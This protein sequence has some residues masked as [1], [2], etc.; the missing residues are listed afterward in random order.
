[1]QHTMSYSVGGRVFDLPSDKVQGFLETAKA[2]G[3][4]PEEAYSYRVSGKDGGSREFTIPRSKYDGFKQTAEANGDTVEPLRTMTMADG[5]RRS[6]TMKEMADYLR[7]DEYRNSQDAKDAR[8]EIEKRLP[9]PTEIGENR[10]FGDEL[11]ASGGGAIGRM[12]GSVVSGLFHAGG[13]LL[14]NAAVASPLGMPG[15]N[16][17]GV[18]SKRALE[19]VKDNSADKA[20]NWVSEWTNILFPEV[21]ANGVVQKATA[22]TAELGAGLA[23][24]GIMA[25][26]PYSLAALV[27]ENAGNSSYETYD[28][29]I[30]GGMSPEEANGLAMARGFVD[31]GI[32]AAFAAAP[33]K[34]LANA[35]GLKTQNVALPA[36]KDA[37]K[38]GAKSAKNQLS[39]GIAKAMAVE[40]AKSAAEMGGLTYAQ[41]FFDNAVMQEAANPDAPID[42]EKAAKDAGWEALEQAGMGAALGLLPTP[43]RIAKARKALNASIA[44][45]V[46]APNGAETFMGVN[47]QGAA[48]L[49]DAYRKNGSVSRKDAAR[50]GLPEMNEADRN[51]VAKRIVDVQERWDTSKETAAAEHKVVEARMAENE[52]K[53]AMG[54]RIEREGEIQRENAAQSEYEAKMTAYEEA[55]AKRAAEKKRGVAKDKLTPL[56]EKPTPPELRVEK[57]KKPVAEADLSEKTE[58]PISEM[59]IEELRKA[60]SEAREKRIEANHA[61]SKLRDRS[62]AGDEPTKAEIEEADA[63]AGKWFR[64]EEETLQRL[65]ELQNPKQTKV[66]DGRGRMVEKPVIE[67]DLTDASKKTAQVGKEAAEKPFEAATKAGN[68]GENLSPRE[69]DDYETRYAKEKA[70]FDAKKPERERKLADVNARIE[71]NDREIEDLRKSFKGTDEELLKSDRRNELT[72]KLGE[73][74]KEKSSIEGELKESET[75]HDRNVRENKADISYV[76]SHISY[77][78]QL[79]K[80]ALKKGESA[81]VHDKYIA[82]YES[83]LKTLKGDTDAR[84]TIKAIPIEPKPAKVPD[85]RGRMV[86]KPSWRT[87]KVDEVDADGKPYTE[88]EKMVLRQMKALDFIDYNQGR[89]TS[90]KEYEKVVKAF[91]EIESAQPF[92]RGINGDVV[93]GSARRVANVLATSK[94]ATPEEKA[95]F[96]EY[97][98]GKPQSPQP[99]ENTPSRAPQ[100][101]KPMSQAEAAK[102][103]EAK[104]GANGAA[105]KPKTYEEIAKRLDELTEVAKPKNGQKGDVVAGNRA[106]G[107]KAVAFALGYDYSPKK[108]ILKSQLE[109]IAKELR[110]NEQPFDNRNSEM[111]KLYD[112]RREGVLEAIKDAGLE[113]YTDENG[114]TQVRKAK[115]VKTPSTRVPDGKGR[116]VK[117]TN[118]NGV[119]EKIA[120]AE[121]PIGLHPKFKKQNA[122][123]MAKIG[124]FSKDGKMPVAIEGFD[125]GASKPNYVEFK[126]DDG[127]SQK[128]YG[129]INSIMKWADGVGLKPSVRPAPVAQADGKSKTKS[130]AAPAPKSTAPVVEK[131][132]G[133]LGTSAEKLKAEERDAKKRFKSE[134]ESLL[135]ALETARVNADNPQ[136]SFSSDEKAK[137][138]WDDAFTKYR[139]LKDVELGKAEAK[140]EN[141][142]RAIIRDKWRS[143]STANVPDST[144]LARS[145]K[146]KTAQKAIADIKA[147]IKQFENDIESFKGE[148][149]RVKVGNTEYTIKNNPFALRQFREN[150]QKRFGKEASKRYYEIDTTPVRDK[151]SD[152]DFIAWTKKQGRTPTDGARR[153]YDAQRVDA[154]LKVAKNWL[155]GVT[156]R[157]TENAAEVPNGARMLYSKD[158]NVVGWYDRAKNEVV[159]L[160]GA[161][162]AT[163]AHELGWHATYDY[164]QA[165]AAQGR[166][167]LLDKLN[168]YAANAPQAVKNEILRK[169]GMATDASTL[170]DEIGAARYTMDNVNKIKDAATRRQ[171]AKW[172]QRT[173]NA[174]ADTYKAMLSKLGW[175]KARLDNLSALTPEETVNLLADEM[176]KGRNLGKA[177]STQIDMSKGESIAQLHDRKLKDRL[178]PI[179]EIEKDA[180]KSVSNS[181]H[182]LFRLLP[183]KV[184]G[185]IDKAQNFAEKVKADC[186]KAGIKIE[187]LN[188]FLYASAAS[189]RNAKVL[190]R[191]GRLDGSAMSHADIQRI[192]SAYRN[193]PK[194]A[195]LRRIADDV[196]AFQRKGFDFRRKAGLI[197]DET[198]NTL[199]ADEPNHVP[200][201]NRFDPNGE[202][203]GF[204]LTEQFG[205]PEW[206]T[207]EGR[208]NVGDGPLEWIVQEYVDAFSRGHENV[209]RRAL[210][211]TVLAH[212]EVGE[213]KKL[214]PNDALG[215]V[216][217]KG[218]Q[219]DPNVFVVKTDGD[220]YQVKLNGTRGELIARAVSG[221]GLLRAP[222]SLQKAMRWWSSTATSWSPTFAGRNFLADTVD[223]FAVNVGENGLIKGTGKFVK[224]VHTALKLTNAIRKYASTGE[225][226]NPL[227]REAV[228]AG[229]LMGGGVRSQ[230]FADSGEAALKTLKTDWRSGKNRFKAVRNAMFGWVDTLNQTAELMNRMADYKLQREAGKSKNEAALHAR[231]ITVDFNEKGELTPVTNMLYMFS[232]STLGATMRLNKAI[233]ASKEGKSLAAGVF[234]WGLVEGMA[235]ALTNGDDEDGKNMNE[236]TR[237]N[238]LYFRNGKD[239]YRIPLHASPIS[240]IKYAGNCTARK[241]FGTLNGDKAAEQ[242]AKDMIGIMT[243]YLGIGALGDNEAAAIAP[244][245]VQPFLQAYMNRDFADRPIERTSF[246]EEK[247]K[248]GNGRPST[249]QFYKDLAKWLNEF[250]G[251]NAG[252]KGELNLLGEKIG[253]DFSPEMLKHFAEATGKNALRD[254]ENTVEFAKMVLGKTDWDRRNIP[255]GRDYFRTTGGNDNRFFEAVRAYKT[256][257][258]ELKNKESWADGEKAAYRKSHP[259]LRKGNDGKTTVN[260]LINMTNRDN[261]RSGIG[262]MGITQLRKLTEGK[263]RRKDGSYFEPK[264]PIDDAKKEKANEWLQKRQARVIEIMGK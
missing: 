177:R 17:S 144:L 89:I 189:E 254:I 4:A 182:T 229:V 206:K 164:A 95:R 52:Q 104:N 132:K 94:F 147:K 234:A 20:G 29:A 75:P 96:K 43:V 64:I 115:A 245:I 111:A 69:K 123:E 135:A 184:Q 211:E 235:E 60:H 193:S 18:D 72:K 232:N 170:L 46:R 33:V 263:I 253:T 219:G 44:D 48:E 154:V 3:D 30:R 247:P 98:E 51:S 256:D 179:E 146:Y 103:V 207:A 221:R 212:P 208:T 151:L 39:A 140:L 22:K 67:A 76:K 169:Y 161:D 126:Y 68:G 23:K 175:N 136:K 71:E 262:S 218:Q 252:R 120:N 233:F 205:K 1:M 152:P 264:T 85:G 8:A 113:A 220:T 171:T 194:Y 57:Q 59:S 187:E 119:Y 141:V 109:Q 63:E 58:K 88:A 227:I 198:W 74:L 24:F 216:K 186:K 73:L 11:N 204:S 66:P 47:P 128:V 258:E 133:G 217:R 228:D 78:K 196:L 83:L 153:I 261:P 92:E 84:E 238:S 62:I 255:V 36:V 230:A 148:D 80:N 214:G 110:A 168:D 15:M 199:L 37:I 50:A 185:A 49:A 213:V 162:A 165:E 55:R 167:A 101:A 209:A 25:S 248:S 190:A 91:D 237:A 107:Y 82:K 87:S 117:K 129:D 53:A 130:V 156:M 61:Q 192:L 7:S 27:A 38:N 249:P 32:T 5:T 174:I 124:V 173:W 239:I 77:L 35:L 210:L 138:F 224:H 21:D 26:N 223:V 134:K 215:E 122:A 102:P 31:G 81:A 56:P 137:E 40:A 149:L 97:Y 143:A 127:S 226:T 178:R 79:K 19:S 9:K 191:N 10:T 106:E 108:R 181:A 34:R 65:G 166:T 41:S 93:N 70:D 54:D 240:V 163:V 2:N 197:S 242:V 244:T 200:M 172:Y 195:E 236:Y 180:G 203:I 90:R 176:L 142:A 250:G 225:T 246:S 100:E 160:P 13:Q 14:R 42:W 6:F 99:R 260:R 202:H 188:E 251:G 114:L 157:R 12:I 125:G 112:A 257:A 150:V 201:K 222:Q 145:E 131:A 45:A 28:A 139:K 231:E 16:L 241:L 158:G 183:G 159:T 86:E 105:S 259:W 155:K 116:M 118:G 243:S 121:L